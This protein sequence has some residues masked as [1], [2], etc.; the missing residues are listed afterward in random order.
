M[1]QQPSYFPSKPRH[2][3]ARVV[4]L[5]PSVRCLCAHCICICG[6]RHKPDRIC[7]YCQHTL[8]NNTIY[9]HWK[10]REPPKQ[11]SLIML[12]FK[13]VIIFLH[14][15][16]CGWRIQFIIAKK[17]R[18]KKS[19]LSQ[20][21]SI[22]KMVQNDSSSPLIQCNMLNL[23]FLFVFVLF[24]Y[25]KKRGNIYSYWQYG[26][27]WICLWIDTTADAANGLKRIPLWKALIL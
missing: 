20:T 10:K 17:K 4:L 6:R 1:C 27:V 24:S 12:V 19:N 9:M 2:I 21:A 25:D 23:I 8:W 16:Y 18:R 7:Q 3:I 11:I 15:T 13:C 26:G 5:A 22:C 14:T